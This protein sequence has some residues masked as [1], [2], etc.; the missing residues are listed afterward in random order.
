MISPEK[1]KQKLSVTLTPK[2]KKRVMDEWKEE[3]CASASDL[4]NLALIQYFERKDLKK[5]S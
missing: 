2:I 5:E 3:G 4:V 1:Q